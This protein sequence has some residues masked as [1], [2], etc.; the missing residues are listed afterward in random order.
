M[1]TYKNVYFTLTKNAIDL[2][3]TCTYE[4][5]YTLPHTL[6]VPFHRLLFE[7]KIEEN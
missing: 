3:V 1:Y 5:S 6:I 4:T 7:R 2:L